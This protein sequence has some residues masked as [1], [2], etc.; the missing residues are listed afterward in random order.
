MK[1]YQNKQR[2]TFILIVFAVIALVDLIIGA[3]FTRLA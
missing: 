3:K 1:T 2:V